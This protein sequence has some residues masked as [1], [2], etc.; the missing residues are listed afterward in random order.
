L[1]SLESIKSPASPSKQR[2]N[3]AVAIVKYQDDCTDSSEVVSQAGL[4]QLLESKAKNSTFKQV[5]YI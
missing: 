3:Q 1:H 4:S 2:A 5:K